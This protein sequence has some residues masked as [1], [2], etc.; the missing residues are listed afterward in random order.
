MLDKFI[1]KTLKP[2]LIVGGLATCGLLYAA[3]LPKSALPAMFKLEYVA[4]YTV[5]AQHWGMMVFCLGA[6][7]FFAGLYPHLRYPALV[8][9]TVEKS[10]ML[11]LFLVYSGPPPT[12]SFIVPF[13]LDVIIVSYSILYFVNYW[14]GSAAR[15][16]SK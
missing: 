2:V 11:G 10:F 12:P 6:F 13:I 14:T 7:L 16:L 8:F 9:S 1:E 4:D 15:A 3:L 5:I